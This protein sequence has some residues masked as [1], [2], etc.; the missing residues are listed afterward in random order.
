MTNNIIDCSSI[1]PKTNT[2]EALS[3]FELKPITTEVINE[4]SEIL[5]KLNALWIPYSKATFVLPQNADKSHIL[6]L[7]KE[8]NSLEYCVGPHLAYLNMY[9]EDFNGIHLYDDFERSIKRI[10]HEISHWLPV[11]LGGKWL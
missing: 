8:S 6:I 5:L 9:S 1:F 2:Q 7:L 10:N 3:G 11:P 4:L